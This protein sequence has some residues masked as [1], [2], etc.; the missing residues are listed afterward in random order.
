MK[1]LIS[2]HVRISYRFYEF[3]T[4]QYTTD[5]YI[6]NSFTIRFLLRD[7]ISNLSLPTCKEDTHVHVVFS[8]TGQSCGRS[9]QDYPLRCKWCVPSLSLIRYRTNQLFAGQSKTGLQVLAS[10]IISYF[11]CG[12]LLIICL[13]V[14]RVASIRSHRTL[15]ING[16]KRTQCVRNSKSVL[17]RWLNTVFDTWYLC[18][19]HLFL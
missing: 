6:I 2:S 15:Y 1:S 12:S 10:S 19:I 14:K 7:Q 17:F 4:T 8:I 3:V 13:D 5:F 9:V 11:S 16:Q 18:F